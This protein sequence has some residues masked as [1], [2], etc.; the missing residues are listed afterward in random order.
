MSWL[1][2]F[3]ASETDVTPTRVVRATGEPH[4]HGR[5]SERCLFEAGRRGRN[6]LMT[7]LVLWHY[8][9]LKRWTWVRLD[10]EL[11]SA[12]DLSA[13]QRQQGIARLIQ[14]PALIQVQDRRNGCPVTARA[15]DPWPPG[16]EGLYFRGFMS[17]RCFREAFLCSRG[18]ALLTYLLIHHEFNLSS[19]KSPMRVGRRKLHKAGISRAGGNRAIDALIAAGLIEVLQRERGRITLVA[20]LDPWAPEGQRRGEV[21]PEPARLPLPEL[22][23][24]G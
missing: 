14:T 8:Q 24:S 3:R 21:S 20:P 13:A 23:R 16:D 9:F 15:I 22:R 4:F 18:N 11:C 7:Y 17:F 12:E 6:A 1:D 5:M 2:E 19:R 10:G